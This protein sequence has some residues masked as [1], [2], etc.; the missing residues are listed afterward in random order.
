MC[1]K[2]NFG[3]TVCECDYELVAWWKIM[4]KGDLVEHYKYECKC[5]KNIMII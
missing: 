1:K 5:C 2:D 4:E 3:N